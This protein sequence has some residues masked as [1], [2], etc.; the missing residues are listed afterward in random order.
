MLDALLTEASF[1][2]T[3][4]MAPL[5]PYDMG[6]DPITCR[7]WFVYK[8]LWNHRGL[9]RTATTAQFMQDVYLSQK[10]LRKYPE[11]VF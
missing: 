6:E 1:K 8:S 5:L 4:A 3:R 7:V 10:E 9:V 2:P 11:R